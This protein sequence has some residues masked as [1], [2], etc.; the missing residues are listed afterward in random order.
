MKESWNKFD[1]DSSKYNKIW[2]ILTDWNFRHDDQDPL[3]NIDLT[4]IYKVI[5]LYNNKTG[6]KY[7]FE[8]I[9]RSNL[10][11]NQSFHGEWLSYYNNH[12][13]LEPVNN[14]ADAWSTW[15]FQNDTYNLLDKN[16]TLNTVEEVK[17]GHISHRQTTNNTFN[18][19]S[20]VEFNASDVTSPK[21]SKEVQAKTSIK[22]PTFIKSNNKMLD[23][24]AMLQDQSIGENQSRWVF[25]WDDK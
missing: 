22:A 24:N 19:D 4:T 15:T 9:F 20:K 13:Q 10:L 11:Q 14:D 18:E 21:F 8:V 12:E 7:K 2:C 23:H 5:P 17:K 16:F 3:F 25:G 1:P 6:A